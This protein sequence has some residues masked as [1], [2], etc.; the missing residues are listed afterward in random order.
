ML[1]IFYGKNL[2]YGNSIIAE[3]NKIVYLKSAMKSIVLSLE[4][5]L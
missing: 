2:D 5:N 1:R 4:I 3:D